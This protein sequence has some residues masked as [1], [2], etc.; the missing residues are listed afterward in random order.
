MATAAATKARAKPPK[1]KNCSVAHGLSTLVLSKGL[2]RFGDFQLAKNGDLDRATSGDFFMA[3]D[4]RLAVDDWRDLRVAA[5][6]IR[7]ERR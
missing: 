2:R 1:P 4:T 7:G 5:E 6:A 3:T